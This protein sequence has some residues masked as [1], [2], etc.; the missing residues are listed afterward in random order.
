M[1]SKCFVLR[2]AGLSNFDFQRSNF[3]VLSRFCRLSSPVRSSTRGV[4]FRSGHTDTPFYESRAPGLKGP[5]YYSLFFKIMLKQVKSKIKVSRFW[6]GVLD[7]APPVH[8][9]LAR[10]FHMIPHSTKHTSKPKP[11][12]TERIILQYHHTCELSFHP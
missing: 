8:V 1:C 2:A 9:A 10:C 11:A 5:R 6:A 7:R 3:V 12:P 4:L